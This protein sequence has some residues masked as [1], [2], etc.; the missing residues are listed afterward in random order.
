MGR[1]IAERDPGRNPGRPSGVGVLDRAAAVLDAVEAGAR[2]FTD[3]ARATGLPRPTAHRLLRAL[4]A[5]GFLS[6]TEGRGYGPGPRLLRLAASALRELPL[7]E[8]AHPAL[9]RTERELAGAP[10]A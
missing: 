2:T 8:L 7:R 4:V 6:Q 5:L 3:V 10:P 9:D 1:R